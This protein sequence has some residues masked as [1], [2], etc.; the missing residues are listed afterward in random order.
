MI[1]IIDLILQFIILLSLVAYV[2]Y[3]NKLTDELQ[4]Q[5]TLNSKHARLIRYREI[6]KNMIEEFKKEEKLIYVTAYMPNDEE[7]EFRFHE[8]MLKDIKDEGR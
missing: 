5:N 8:S 7:T 3:S 1:E 6:Y 2:Y 4:K